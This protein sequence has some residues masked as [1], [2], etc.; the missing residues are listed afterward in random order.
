MPLVAQQTAPPEHTTVL[1]G[2]LLNTSGHPIKTMARSSSHS[3]MCPTSGRKSL[4]FREREKNKTPK[5]KSC[6][7][8]VAL[9]CGNWSHD[10]GW[11]LPTPDQPRLR[12]TPGIDGANQKQG[13]KQEFLI[14][15]GLHNLAYLWPGFQLVRDDLIGRQS[16]CVMRNDPKNA[17]LH[18][19]P[20]TT[21]GSSA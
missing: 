7:C 9:R 13:K 21:Q 20:S 8:T 5:K 3:G 11:L 17:N 4:L 15:R 10:R 18:D 2:W 14:D 6:S 16:L 12:R 19:I 1:T